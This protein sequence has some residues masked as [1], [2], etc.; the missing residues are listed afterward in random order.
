VSIPALVG[1]AVLAPDFVQIVLG[2]KWADATPVIQILAVV[3][4]IQS[5]QTL[6]GEVL[7]ALGRAN[8]LLRFTALWFIASLASFALGIRWGVV[9]IAACY[10]VATLLVEPVRTYITAR[11]LGTSPWS[12][13]AALSG[14]TQAAVL[15]AGFLLVA[16]SA[17]VAANVPAGAR[18]ALLVVLGGGVYI[19]ACLWRATE[20][21]S[22]IRIAIGVRRG[23]AHAASSAIDAPLERV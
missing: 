4:I 12:F 6:C 22:E 15:M 1:L 14:I 21:V 9:G 3:G 8:W 11:A 10:A 16:R 17:L 23:D 13:V 20:V 2:P 7:L 19:V 5:L 18:L